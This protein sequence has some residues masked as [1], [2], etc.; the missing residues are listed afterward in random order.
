MVGNGLCGNWPTND[1]KSLDH[2]TQVAFYHAD[3]GTDEFKI[4]YA[5]TL[6]KHFVE[7]KRKGRRGQSQPLAYWTMVGYHPAK[8]EENTPP[9]DVEQHP[10]LGVCYTVRINIGD[11]IKEEFMTR[12]QIL[13]KFGRKKSTK[14]RVASG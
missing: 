10:Q 7:K 1:F 5:E 14:K 2:K 12:T 8:N 9:E 3:A 11:E 6:A 4:R 13:E